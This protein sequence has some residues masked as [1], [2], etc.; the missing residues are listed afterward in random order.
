M[1]AKSERN[2]NINNKAI[3]NVVDFDIRLN[4]DFTLTAKKTKIIAK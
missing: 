4:R 1:F 3:L 2:S